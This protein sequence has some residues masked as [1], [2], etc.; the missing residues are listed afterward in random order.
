MTAK[1]TKTPVASK[2]VTYAGD[3]LKKAWEG[4][5]KGDNEAYPK[6]TDLQEAWRAFHAGDFAKA[7]ERGGGHAV[8]V[9]ATSIYANH[10]E[11]ND[12][13]KI[14]LFQ[15]AMKLAEALMTSEPKNTNAFYQYA[16]AAGRYSQSIS[17]M[18]ALKEGYGG[19]IKNAL[20]TALKLDPKHADAHTAMGAYHAEI[21][22][23]VGAMI[24]KLTYGANKD[25]A[26]KHYET[27]IKLNPQSPIANIEYA[28]GLLMLFGDKEV[29]KATK[30]YEK[31][32]KMKGRDAMEL[33]DVEIA[34]AELEDE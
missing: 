3:A 27:G 2:S 13:A 16:Y 21:I 30:L 5:H 32:A 18:K 25:D 10:V 9:K 24:G 23:K 8:A 29:G 17:V 22:D 1:W 11:K 7:A 4:L 19:K 6:D 31:A 12:S 28:N 14:K 26:V 34:A 33:M 15:D 20:E